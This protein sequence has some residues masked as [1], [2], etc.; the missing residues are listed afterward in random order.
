MVCDTVLKSEFCFNAWSRVTFGP[1]FNFVLA[2]FT[3][4]LVGLFMPKESDL[5]SAKIDKFDDNKIYRVV[6]V[7]TPDANEAVKVS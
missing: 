1:I 7:N 4:I 2:L 5:V 3:F 6:S